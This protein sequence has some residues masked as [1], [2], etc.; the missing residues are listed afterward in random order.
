MDRHTNT[1]RTDET[2]GIGNSNQYYS[3]NYFEELMRPRPQSQ[4]SVICFD[5]YQILYLFLC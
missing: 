4:Y 5:V 3:W 2:G 1:K